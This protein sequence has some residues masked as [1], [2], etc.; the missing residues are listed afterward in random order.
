MAERHIACDQRRDHDKGAAM[1]RSLALDAGLDK[2][3]DLLLT[4]SAGDE[5]SLPH[6]MQISGLPAPQCEAV[7]EALSRAGLMVRSQG[8][9][10]VRKHL[11]G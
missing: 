5:V 4:M 9:A 11:T 6:A 3:Q 10:Y 8:D 2:L 7:L 1:G